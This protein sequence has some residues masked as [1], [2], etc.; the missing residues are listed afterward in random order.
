MAELAQ[1]EAGSSVK[2]FSARFPGNKTIDEGV[3]I[4]E[5]CKNSNI[6]NVS[7]EIST[8]NL[9]ETIYKI[10]Y[11]QEEPFLSSSIYAQWKVM[12]KA[13]Q[14]NVTI[15][16]DGQGADEILAGYLPYVN[17]F[18][19]DLLSKGKLIS[20]CKEFCAVRMKQCQAMKEYPA[21]QQRSYLFTV[22]ALA[23]AFLREKIPSESPFQD[24]LTS[25]LYI[26]LTRNSIPALLRYSDRNSMAFFP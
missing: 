24:R 12:E 10:H 11:Y 1:G 19:A 21:Y 14:S 7:A 8:E 5:V 13:K 20:F 26:D 17:L 9:L 4:D 6:Q 15:L 25:R 23:A 16:L 22:K 3:F 2:T 18:Q